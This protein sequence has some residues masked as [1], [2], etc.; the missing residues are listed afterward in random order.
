MGADGPDATKPAVPCDTRG[1]L[2]SRT[3]LK[4][5]IFGVN[6]NA[7]GGFS[8]SPDRHEID[9]ANNVA[10][11]QR[12]EAVGFD[13]AIPFSRWRGFEGE[14][15]PWGVSFETNTWAAAIAAVTSRICVFTTSQSLTMSPV[16]AAKQ[17][18][19]IDH[20]SAGRVALNVVA[21]WNEREMRM[22]TPMTL[23]H[24]ERY[25]YLGEWME[26]LYG[27][28]AGDEDFDYSGRWLTVPEAYQ[29]PKPVQRPRPPVMNAAFSQRGH[30]FAARYA[31]IAFVNV[32]DPDGARSKAAEIRDLAAAHGREL[33]VWLT[34]AC[35][36]ADTDKAAADVIRSYQD[37]AD[38]AAI[39]NFMAW[40]LGGAVHMAPEVRAAS[41]RLAASGFGYQLVGSA[42][43][44]AERIGELHDAGI[45]GL[46]ITWMNYD[47]GLD[48]FA[49]E[50]MPLLEKNGVR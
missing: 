43:T 3:G 15:N 46:A 30:Q 32:T 37:E 25:D 5:G 45:D 40:T 17:L 18:T 48:R 16:L 33:Q 11:I 23:E 24:D 12:A 31:D 28:F 36:T 21:G 29:Q 8:K 19:T 27:L 10:L 42:E 20:I 50:V 34:A 38:Q 26:V 22:F 35:V 4:L 14:T 1:P 7:G 47:T 9:W 2:Y 44:V 13:A 49:A 6:V 41:E 39:H